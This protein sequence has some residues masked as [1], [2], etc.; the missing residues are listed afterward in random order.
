MKPRT[1]KILGSTSLLLALIAVVS[2]FCIA[3]CDTLEQRILAL[4]LFEDLFDEEYGLLLYSFLFLP[5]GLVALL[6]SI[7]ARR[8]RIGKAALVASILAVF[9]PVG[10]VIAAVIYAIVDIMINPFFFGPP[11]R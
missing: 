1:T 6:L 5:F 10:C 4:P 3:L 9:M 2:P 7:L 11:P 8:L